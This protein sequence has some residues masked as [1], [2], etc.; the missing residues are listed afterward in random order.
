[1]TQSQRK[2]VFI[3]YSHADAEW[4]VRLNV[5]LESLEWEG[6]ID[7]WSDEKIHAGSDWKKEIRKALK[8]AKVAVLLV[9]ADFLASEFIFNDELPPLLA[10]AEKED[11]HILPVIVSRSSFEENESLSRYQ[12]VNPPNKPLLSMSPEEVED[13]FCNLY[14][15]IVQILRAQEVNS[16]QK[17]S[18]EEIEMT[19]SEEPVSEI[20]IPEIELRTQPI[21]DFSEDEVEIMIKE[22]GYFDSEINPSGTGIAH[23][24]QI[25]ADGKIIYDHATGL[26]WQQ[27][28]SDD[29]MPYVDT[30][31]YIKALNSLSFAGYRGWRLPTME[32]SM[33]LL[34]PKKNRDMLYIDR[35]FDKKQEWIW[36][37]DLDI[38]LR[39][40]VVDFYAGG[41][42]DGG[43]VILSNSF[44]Y[45]RAVR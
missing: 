16:R 21:N 2:N 42:I 37:S 8:A 22:K 35:V 30:K 1:M 19:R 23:N 45:V 39:G 6:V 15:S 38:T 14:K 27:S 3:S 20:A 26:M 24:Y 25:R 43:F 5:H 29:K 11:A 10:A 40:W 31:S 17:T 9:C 7:L 13:L 18:S 4:L 41:C 36:T 32:E 12:A 33:S 44:V 34:E 28:G